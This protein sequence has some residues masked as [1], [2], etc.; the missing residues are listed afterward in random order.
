MD[1]WR[2]PSFESSLCNMCWAAPVALSHCHE[3]ARVE[4]VAHRT[5]LQ[6]GSFR[7]CCGGGDGA[8]W[9]IGGGEEATGQT[10]A[11]GDVSLTALTAILSSSSQRPGSTVH[12]R[13]RRQAP[14]NTPAVPATPAP[15][16]DP[17]ATPCLTQRGG[18]DR[19]TDSVQF[20]LYSPRS[21]WRRPYSTKETLFHDKHMI[22]QVALCPEVYRP[23]SG[24]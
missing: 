13:A 15:P 9:E 2:C 23:F 12:Y 11:L 22:S 4:R 10:S 5:Y 17:D 7:S 24:A 21:C 18:A 3:G 16:A 14:T 8:H 1:F 20:Y 6:E 19:G